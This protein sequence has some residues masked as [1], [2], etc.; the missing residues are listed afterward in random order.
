LKARDNFLTRAENKMPTLPLPFIP[1]TFL[2]TK[3][4]DCSA[5]AIIGRVNLWHFCFWRKC[6][7][8]VERCPLCKGRWCKQNHRPCTPLLMSAIPQ[9][10]RMWFVPVSWFWR[11]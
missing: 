4:E 9:L 5:A 7:R 2:T 1:C 11:A 10:C 8:E 3:R 6:N